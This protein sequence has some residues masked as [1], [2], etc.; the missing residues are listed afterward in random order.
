MIHMYTCVNTYCQKIPLEFLKILL[1][2]CVLEI[3]HLYSHKRGQNLISCFIVYIVK[4]YNQ[5][6]NIVFENTSR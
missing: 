1:N 4:M 6:R 5:S 2:H 3:T